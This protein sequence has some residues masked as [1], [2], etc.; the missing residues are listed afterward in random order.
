MSVA[1]GWPFPGPTGSGAGSRRRVGLVLLA[2]WLKSCF[3]GALPPVDFRAVCLVRAVVVLGC[4]A[5][6]SAAGAGA[7]TSSP[8]SKRSGSALT[9][10]SES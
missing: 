5:G 10:P 6:G 2:A 7:G 9:H 8:T 3:L 1:G 4:S